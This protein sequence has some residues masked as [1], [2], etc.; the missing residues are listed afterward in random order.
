MASD[1]CICRTKPTSS[2]VDMLFKSGVEVRGTADMSLSATPDW[3]ADRRNAETRPATCR[4]TN[5]LA[6][7]LCRRR[8]RISVLSARDIRLRC[9][10][11]TESN[12]ASLVFDRVGAAGAELFTSSP[13]LRVTCNC[14]T[15]SEFTPHAEAAEMDVQSATTLAADAAYDIELW[16]PRCRISIRCKEGTDCAKNWA[17]VPSTGRAKYTGF[18]CAALVSGGQLPP[19]QFPVAAAYISRTVEFEFEFEI[20]PAAA[21]HAPL[22]LM[23]MLTV[24]GAADFRPTLHTLDDDKLSELKD[25]FMP[26]PLT[27]SDDV[28]P[29]LHSGK[30]LSWF[31]FDSV[32]TPNVTG[33]RAGGRRAN[34]WNGT[35]SSASPATLLPSWELGG[36]V[37]VACEFM[38]TPAALARPP[39]RPTALS[40]DAVGSL[41]SRQGALEQAGGAVS[42]VTA[43]A[44]TNIRVLHDLARCHWPSNYFNSSH[45]SQREQNKQLF[46]CEIPTAICK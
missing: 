40:N 37:V 2:S 11:T 3:Q 26:T 17:R 5:E 7:R 25:G 8:R 44:I 39:I 9:L 20:I 24:R 29:A 4:R 23:T 15:T 22:F 16:L 27:M 42:D 12:V 31:V 10:A 14:S 1:D 33:G 35:E 38:L 36:N 21:L 43:G 34:G 45:Y 30:H 6:S 46:S 41:V 18:I 19:L 32:A 13:A 28:R